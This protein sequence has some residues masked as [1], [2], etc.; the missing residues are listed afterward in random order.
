[1]PR[2]VSTEVAT[3]PAVHAT[4]RA[5]AMSPA[6]TAMPTIGTLATP[7]EKVIGISRNSR[8]APMP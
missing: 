2:A 4:L 7:I 8:R 5:R 1:M 3:T 6:P